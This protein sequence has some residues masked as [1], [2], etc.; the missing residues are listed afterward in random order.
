MSIFYIC[1]KPGGGKSYLGV[2]QMVEELAI[3]K[4]DRFIVTNIELIFG[5][6][7]VVEEI[8]LPW[9][10]RHF[11]WAMR[12]L[13]RPEP[14]TERKKTLK[15]LASYCHEKF[16]HEV[17]LRERIRILDDQE[18]GEFW[19]YEPGRKFDGRKSLKVGKHER[20]VP[21]FEDR[22]KRGCLYVIDECHNYFPAREWQLTGQD[23]TFFLSQHRKLNCDVILITQHP[24]QCDKAL[25]RLA[26]EY[27]TVRNLSREPF[28][29]FNLA[30]W[31][32]SFRF[33]RML[34]SPQS[35]NPC[36]FD[37]GF[38]NLNPEE[39]GALYD[40]MQGVG[41]AGRVIAKHEARGRSLWWVL[42][43]V[44]FVAFCAVWIFT[45]ISQIDAYIAHGM[46]NVLFHASTNMV[47]AVHLPGP[48]A[49]SSAVPAGS[50]PV[51]AAVASP[52]A[53]GAS[54]GP[55]VTNALWCT[56]YC[57]IGGPKAYLSDGSVVGP[58]EGLQQVCVGFVIVNGEKLKLRKW[59][60]GPHLVDGVLLG[61]VAGPVY[62]HG[63]GAPVA[64]V[65]SEAAPVAARPAASASAEPV[66]YDGSGYDRNSLIQILPAIHAN[67]SPPAQR[68]NGLAS[69]R[70]GSEL[71][72]MG[73]G[74]GGY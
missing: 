73:Y 13:G 32:G 5:D 9:V 42:V 45:H 69:M 10:W 23:A 25:R 38:V 53:V 14:E 35:A 3:E 51:P 24:E 18:A 46:Q 65:A 67:S 15:G 22:A 27:M 11:G 66:A 12:L 39:I 31:L 19:L 7:E 33:L 50:L 40:T 8:P 2:R 52:A 61:G 43:P 1:G 28:L 70:N 55:P 6:R 57:L 47:S 54:N 62:S 26:Q 56:G 58:D 16:K 48:V 17:D 21:D 71:G 30:T 20:D 49:A 63:T 68:I 74:G 59:R 60:D 44:G 4:S 36:V 34:N 72:R 37:S 41:I 64:V 29:G